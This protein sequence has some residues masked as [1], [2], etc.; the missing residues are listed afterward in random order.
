LVETQIEAQLQVASSAP[1]LVTILEIGTA[2][3]ELLLVQALVWCWVRSWIRMNIALET[4]THPAMNADTRTLFVK[5][6]IN[7]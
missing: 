2:S 1:L 7:R 6:V 4:D 5:V 3:K